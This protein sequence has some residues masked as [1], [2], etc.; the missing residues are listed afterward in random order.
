MKTNPANERIKHEYLDYL[1]QARRLNEQSVD[2]AAKALDRFE[3]YTKRRDFKTFHRHQASAFK[4]HLANHLN[5]RTGE[6]LSKATIHSTLAA[7]KSF[8][9]WL[10]DRPGYKSKLQYD[11]ADY[12]NT[13]LKDLAIAKAVREPRVPTIEQIRSVLAA[14]PIESA[15]EKRNRALIAFS[16][17]TGARDNAIASMLI[18]HVDL[19]ERQVF[20]DARDVRTKFSK[21]FPTYFFPVGTTSRRSLASGWHSCDPSWALVP[22]IRSSR[23][24][25]RVSTPTAISRLLAS[26]ANAGRPRRRSARSSKKHSKLPGCPISTRIPSAKR[27]RGLGWTL[28]LVTLA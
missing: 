7:L 1:K 19:G 17:L 18:K 4:G 27:S 5:A 22:T 15:I 28:A 25:R 16:L 3:S 21:S 2:A 14:M 8:F 9:F 20:H 12:F 24:P 11:D 6:K 26:R 13:S 23:R 10:A